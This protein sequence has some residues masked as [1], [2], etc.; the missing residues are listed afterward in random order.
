MKKTI[1]S[2]VAMLALSSILLASCGDD[3]KTAIVDPGPQSTVTITLNNGVHTQ[4]PISQFPDTI[5]IAGTATIKGADKIARLEVRRSISNLSGDYKV[6]KIDS[7]LNTTSTDVV[8]ND[9][10]TSSNLSSLAPEDK[11][12]YL[13]LVTDSKGVLTKDSI[14]FIVKQQT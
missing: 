13:V 9:V 1:K 2:I 11:I 12:T 3:S 5:K 6:M 7:T 14:I 4:I 10:P 8:I